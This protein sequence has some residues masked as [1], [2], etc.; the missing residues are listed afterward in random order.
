MNILC[1]LTN[2]VFRRVCC[3][4]F[5]FAGVTWWTHETFSS[6]QD[7][8]YACQQVRLS[9]DV[10]RCWA[11]CLS[12]HDIS[13][14]EV[15]LSCGLYTTLPISHASWDFVIGLARTRNGKDFTFVVVDR[16]SKMAHFIPCNTSYHA[17]H[18]PTLL[19]NEIL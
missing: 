15:A 16:F 5:F 14:R 9:N 12:M 10:L 6:Q 13:Q 8:S 17:S 18:A 4:C 2:F 19:C 7:T 3:V 1:A 11:L